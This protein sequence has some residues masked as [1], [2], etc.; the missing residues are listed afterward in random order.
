MATSIVSWLSYWLI[1]SPSELL[2]VFSLPLILIFTFLQRLFCF[3]S[4]L[5]IWL[6]KHRTFSN[7]GILPKS[8][9]STWMVQF[10]LSCILPGVILHPLHSLLCSK[11]WLTSFHGSSESVS[12]HGQQLK[13][14]FCASHLVF[15]WMEFS[16]T[17]KDFQT[18]KL[19][20]RF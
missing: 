13:K 11:R 10:H 3:C 17:Y 5:Y 18:W 15:S 7:W 16:D 2:W 19:I 12:V 4:M 9:L 8:M 6:W 1:S 20:F 14:S